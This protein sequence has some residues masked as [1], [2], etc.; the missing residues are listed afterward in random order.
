MPLTTCS[1]VRNRLEGIRLAFH[2]LTR[3]RVGGGGAWK[4]GDETTKKRGGE[5]R[6]SDTD[7]S[8]T[9]LLKTSKRAGFA[10]FLASTFLKVFYHSLPRPLL[11]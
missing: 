5:S 2:V 7:S 8:V 9:F 4:W 3:L 6:T 1:E 10:I 11:F